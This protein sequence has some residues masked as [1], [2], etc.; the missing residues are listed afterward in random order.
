MANPPNMNDR[1]FAMLHARTTSLATGDAIAEPLIATSVYHLPNASDPTRV[2][3]RIDN[4]TVQAVEVRIGV[5]EDA[6]TLLFPSGMA[7]YGALTMALLKAGDTVLLLSDGYFA[8]RAMYDSILADF[9][10]KTRLVAA[11][12]IAEALLD[13]I[14]MVL[15][16]TPSNPTLDLVDIAALAVRCRA[17]G[18][19][20]VV[21]N[22]VCTPLLQQP[23]DLGA[24]VVISSDTKAM[25]G[26]SD[27]LMGHIS[28][29]DAGMM[30]RVQNVRNL[31]GAIPGPFEAWLLLRGL[32][33]L[34]LRLSRMCANA[35]AIVP[36]LRDHNAVKAL[37][38]P[39]SNSAQ[40]A[41]PGFL[42]GVTFAD[43]AAAGRFIDGASPMIPA[44]S[45]GGLHTSADRRARWGD[46]VEDG[47]LRLSLGCEPEAQI[48]DAIKRGLAAV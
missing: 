36:V 28:S 45:F 3:G 33:T 23:L 9:D 40:M 5:L 43:T 11:R 6:P 34:E 44:T 26:H 22:T 4:A 13:G 25:S 15:I 42:I 17:A 16:E 38:Y 30:E 10:I 48:V 12:D 32:E 27:V 29:R 14:K 21:D 8:A 37:H 18:C 31:M 41:H 1:V 24:D 7:T 46:D 20:L 39:A 35:D 47:F 2:Y 19:I